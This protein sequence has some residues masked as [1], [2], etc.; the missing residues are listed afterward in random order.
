MPLI[1]QRGF[2]CLERL[3]SSGRFH[4]VV[5]CLHSLTPLFFSSP[6]EASSSAGFCAALLA[7]AEADR[8]VLRKARRVEQQSQLGVI[9]S[10]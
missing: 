6:E 2:D 8:S 9:Y 3:A 4:Q 5:E 1:C 7:L 10:T